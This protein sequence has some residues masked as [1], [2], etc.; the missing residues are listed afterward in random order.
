MTERIDVDE[1]IGPLEPGTVRA[2][3]ATTLNGSAATPEG[4]SGGLGNRTDTELLLRVREVVDVIIVSA[5]TVRAE[6][7]GPAHT[8]TP[9]A[10][11]SRSLDFDTSTRFF[12][13]AGPIVLTPQ[14][15]V[16]D[17]ALASRR[18]EL[19]DAGARLLSSGDGSPAAMLEALR[20]IGLEDVSLEGGPSLYEAFLSAGLIDV[21]HVT[22]DPSV[23][24][25]VETPVLANT[26][27]AA[28]RH[29]LIL[30]SVR[31]TDDGCLFLRYRRA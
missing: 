18:E 23:V 29:R 26:D 16:D 28:A 30:E 25:P 19:A 31:G 7:Y 12:S 1:L 15:C 2:I 5:G 14:T 22:V 3:L 27:A 4:T 17:P 13:G 6:D 20:T 11:V 8:G 10:V 24:V 9:I 21:W